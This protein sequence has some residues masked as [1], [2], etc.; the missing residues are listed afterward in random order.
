MPSMS[1][2]RGYRFII[3]MPDP[4][5][6]SKTSTGIYKGVDCI[7]FLDKQKF[8]RAIESIHFTTLA[9][10]EIFIEIPTRIT[11][12][13]FVDIAAIEDEHWLYSDEEK[14]V[15]FS[16]APRKENLSSLSRPTSV[17]WCSFSPDSTRLATCTSDGFINLWN[18][19]TSQVYQRFRSILETSSAACWWSHKYLF[20]CHVIDKIPSLSRYP[21]DGSLKIIITEKQPVPLCSV[22]D[23]FL[24]FSGFLYFSEGYL[25]FECGETEPVKVLDIE[26]IGRPKE[27]ILPGIR[28]MMSIAV[29]SRADFVLA[30]DFK[31]CFLW[32]G[33]RTQPSM[34]DVFVKHDLTTFGIFRSRFFKCCF[35]NDSQFALASSE[36]SRKRRFFVIDVNTGIEATHEIQENPIPASFQGVEKIFSIDT[37]AILLTPNLIQIFDLVNWKR[38]ESSFQRYVTDDILMHSKLSPKGTVLAVPRLT[39]DMEFFHLRI[40]MHSSVSNGQ[41]NCARVGSAKRSASPEPNR[42]GNLPKVR[43]NSKES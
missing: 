8:L 24:P 36:I 26:K 40:P 35:S 25:S 17:L 4:I 13:P 22:N 20:V 19:E 14:L 12:V 15:V 10:W 34:Y 23:T 33:N 31:F 3:S 7:F 38:L 43:K 6:K 28:S 41:E 39:G 29:S 37:I 9:A 27:V 1:L 18:V 30:T 11:G 42:F 5:E 21:V 32:K 2:S 16:S